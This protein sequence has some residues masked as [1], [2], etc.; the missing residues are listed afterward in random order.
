MGRKR[1]LL[2]MGVCFALAM[3]GCSTAG[4]EASS[5]T[6]ARLT[7]DV[8]EETTIPE[9]TEEDVQIILS[10]ELQGIPEFTGE[11]DFTY[12][13][14]T[15]AQGESGDTSN[16]AYTREGY[17]YLQQLEMTEGMML[18]YYDWES[19]QSVP[20]CSKSNCNHKGEGC[21][22]YFDGAEYPLTRLCY[23]QGNL[24]AVKQDG[25][26]FGIYKISEDGAVREKSC[27]LMRQYVEEQV[28]DDGTTT[29]S[30][31][32]PTVQIHRGYVYFTDCYPG[33]KSCGLYRVKLDSQEEPEVLFTL[34]ENSPH[35]Y[36]LTAY[37]RYVL[38]KMGNFDDSYVNFSG[39]LYVYD[40]QEGTISTIGEGL[41]SGSCI[42]NQSL[43]YYDSQNNILKQDLETSQVILFY[44]NAQEQDVY[45]NYNYEK[46][47]FSYGSKLVFS[48]NNR[49]TGYCKQIVLDENGAVISTLEGYEEEDMLHPYTFE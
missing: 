33:C 3:T 42:L 1:M 36:S 26:Y 31:H 24:Y 47:L 45:D 41:F 46:K 35:I 11:L 48:F 27:T 23:N 18:Y 2:S 43:Y 37:G 38:F 39:G 21:D 10:E 40:T 14:D 34:S 9:S 5:E 15:D 32:Y 16:V 49:E 6:S 4:E 22:G 7:A 25:D 30:Y 44:E 8:L 29:T 28:Y 20:V 12:V 19:G 13:F 17:Y